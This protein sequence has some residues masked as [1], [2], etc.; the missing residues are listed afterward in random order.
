M[1][2]GANQ[3][4]AEGPT[5][6]AAS[7]VQYV[8][9]H[10]HSRKAPSCPQNRTAR[11]VASHERFWLG[12]LS[13]IVP[14]P[15]RRHAYAASNHISLTRTEPRLFFFATAAALHRVLLK[16]RQW[17]KLCWFLVLAPAFAATN[18]RPSSLL[19]GNFARSP[20]VLE[21]ANCRSQP[22]R[23]RVL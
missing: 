13:D 8:S 2:R 11:N 19:T 22:F 17:R 20:Q 21:A 10:L 12:K 9:V 7:L 6:E 15:R 14:V 4:R 23:R 3:K 18:F 1:S 5:H 16:F